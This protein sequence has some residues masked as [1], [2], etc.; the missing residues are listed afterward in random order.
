MTVGSRSR[1]TMVLARFGEGWKM[2]H[3]HFSSFPDMGKKELSR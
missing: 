2:V 3:E 1:V